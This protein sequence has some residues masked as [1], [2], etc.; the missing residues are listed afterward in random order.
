[1]T[2]PPAHLWR[3]R[4]AV[5]AIFF[6]NGLGIGAWAAAIPGLKLNHALSDATLS[7]VLLAFA[8]G[9]VLSMPLA[10]VL[11]AR[12]GAHRITAFAAF[13]FALTLA[14]PPFARSVTLLSTFTFLLGFS[15]GLLDV[16]MNALA[17]TVEKKWGRAIMS[18]FH[19]AFSLG[20]LVGAG[21]GALLGLQAFDLLM[22]G[23]AG[24]SIILSLSALPYLNT[25][26]LPAVAT[27]GKWAMPSR[28]ALALCM[29]TALCMLVEGAMADWSGVYIATIGNP[30]SAGIGFAAFS[31]T[32]TLG[33]LTG[34]RMVN[35]LGHARVIQYGG[36]LSMLGL[37][38]ATAA[39]STAWAV[40]G[41]ALVG[42]GLANIVPSVFSAASKIGSNAA[43]G[44]AMVATTGYTGFLGGPPLV[45]LI[46]SLSSLRTAVFM[47]AIASGLIMLVAI[48]TIRH[49]SN[50]DE[51]R[52]AAD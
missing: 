47:L 9:A 7:L 28:A 48:V 18:S 5:T 20:G 31:L 25:G 8:A 46:S 34:D 39:P 26:E 42:L 37:L 24:V 40:P 6:G 3:T 51:R 45:G 14:L 12:K 32:M 27:P 35:A 16:S 1:M 13:A 22:W 41:F 2:M 49:K 21:C 4:L 52:A 10:G 19:A 36:A 50:S 11:A 30:N 44:V 23:C 17:S 43:S 38:C 33:R 29:I 15:N